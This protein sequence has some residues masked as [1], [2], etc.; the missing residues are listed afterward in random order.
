MRYHSRWLFAFVSC[1]LLIGQ[2][3][4]TALARS[5]D[6]QPKPVSG[7]ESDSLNSSHVTELAGKPGKPRQ[8]E[9]QPARST[10]H[11]TRQS[12]IVPS[13]VVLSPESDSLISEPRISEHWEVGGAGQRRGLSQERREPGT[14]ML[15][16][17]AVE[18]EAM[19]TCTAVDASGHG[20]TLAGPAPGKLRPDERVL[21]SILAIRREQ[22][23]LFDGTL[24]EELA[25]P[26][27]EEDFLNALRG[28]AANAPPLVRPVQA[29]RPL[30]AP[31]RS[32]L[33]A[34]DSQLA[35]TLR[36]ASR[37][38]DGKAADLEDSCHYKQADQLRSL[39]RKLRKQARELG[40]ALEI[41]K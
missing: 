36:L 17:G 14:L 8:P 30:P 15:G 16:P 4:W 6:Q 13:D 9:F 26:T 10:N 28:V 23:G 37:Q 39:A 21:Q 22:G 18:S 31:E 11:E 33:G 12:D 38:L 19:A 35:Q 41:E 25:A 20:P 32:N 40:S 29:I 3:S 34:S 7:R 24:L 27:A 5:A 1:A 2:I